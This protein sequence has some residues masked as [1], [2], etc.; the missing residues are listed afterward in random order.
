MWAAKCGAGCDGAAQ[1]PAA[2]GPRRAGVSGHARASK[3]GALAGVGRR[4]SPAAAAP[5]TPAHVVSVGTGSDM[6]RARTSRSRSSMTPFLLALWK[7]AFLREPDHCC[8]ARSLLEY[9]S[10]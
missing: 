8:R 1:A 4:C 7:Q 6:C 9:R 2:G 3:G 10:E 5:K